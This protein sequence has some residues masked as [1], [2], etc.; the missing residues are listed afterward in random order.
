MYVFN[1][2]WFYYRLVFFFSSFLFK[3]KCYIENNKGELELV[4]LFFVSVVNKIFV[5][6]W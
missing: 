2:F 1:F 6:F 4:L 5:V 3:L